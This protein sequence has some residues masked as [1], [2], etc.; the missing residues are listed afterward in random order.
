MESVLLCSSGFSTSIWS[1]DEELKLFR[2]ISIASGSCRALDWNQ[3]NNYIFLCSSNGDMFLQNIKKETLISAK[4]QVS[5]DAPIPIVSGIILSGS[6]Y[7]ITGDVEGNIRLWPIAKTGFSAPVLDVNYPGCQI[8]CFVEYSTTLLYACTSQGNI[9][10]VNSRN[11]RSELIATIENES[12]LSIINENGTLFLSTSSGSIYRM[13]P[14]IKRYTLVYSSESSTPLHLSFSLSSQLNCVVCYSGTSLLL[15]N[16]KTNQ[17]IGI[18]QTPTAIVAADILNDRVVAATADQRLLLWSALNLSAPVASV[19]TT[20]PIATLR[21]N[22]VLRSA[23][24]QT[25]TFST[26]QK[27]SNAMGESMGTLPTS[28]I[29]S[30]PSKM[31]VEETERREEK[32]QSTIQSRGETILEGVE[33]ANLREM[34]MEVVQ[35]MIFELQTYV[36]REVSD[37]KADMIRQFSDQEQIIQQQRDQ[38]ELLLSQFQQKG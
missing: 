33:S 5:E 14:L 32:I 24:R 26:P 31:L 16:L 6:R 25:S 15:F 12:I 37:L 2:E 13:L 9:I 22:R 20:Q 23:S 28:S 10:E 17:I 7:V 36:H 38:I 3:N 19:F 27:Q 34:L 21:F 1:V 4:N 30:T 8:T 29:T 35:P 18:L 11:Y